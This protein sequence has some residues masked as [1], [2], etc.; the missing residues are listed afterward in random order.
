MVDGKCTKRYP[1]DFCDETTFDGSGYPV[2]CRRNDGNTIVVNNIVV[3][4]RWVIPYNLEL[5][6]RF[7]CHINVEIVSYFR[8]IKYLYKYVHKGP[9]RATIVIEDNNVAEHAS[10]HPQQFRQVDEV[11][12]YL[13]C[14]YISSSEA[15]WRVFEFDL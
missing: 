15:C 9:D 7:D 5:V 13:D 8:I 1:R 11:K 6:M 10:G 4:N 14:R 12:Q 2:Y 3:N